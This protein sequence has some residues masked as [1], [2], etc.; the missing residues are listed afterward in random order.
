MPS[1]I[2]PEM[3]KVFAKAG[4]DFTSET[5]VGTVEAPGY[6]PAWAGILEAD[7]HELWNAHLAQKRA[8]LAFA[9]QRLFVQHARHGEGPADLRELL[10]SLDPDAFIIGFARR[11]ATYK[12]ASL[13][14]NDEDR[15][16]AILNAPGR[17]VQ[18]LFS[19]KSH[20]TDRGGQGLISQVYEK[21][22]ES[23]FKGKVFLLEDYDIEVGRSLV[24]GVD[25]WLNN[26]RRPLE[27]SGTSGMKAAA[28]GVP[29]VSI[30]DGWWDEAYEGDP[31]R[32]GWA[33]GG[34]NVVESSDEQDRRDAAEVY[35]ILEQEVIPAYFDR[36]ATGL[37][38]RWLPVMKRAIA[39]SV[40][41]FSTKRMLDDY[42]NQMLVKG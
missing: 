20:P 6:R 35:R 21:T 17:R 32:N 2:G 12:R 33:I 14:F 27:A 41:A 39:S 30:L 25:M 31:N 10:D 5:A 16:D 8:L 26:P 7:D 18:I 28:N 42:L 13:I 15:L 38:S 3:M 1:W 24:Q 29:N 11:F 23:R 37:P 36:D 22:Q 40:Y 34:R 9:K 4:A 19:G